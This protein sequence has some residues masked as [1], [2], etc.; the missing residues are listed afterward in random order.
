MTLNLKEIIY[1]KQLSTL[2][3]NLVLASYQKKLGDKLGVLPGTE[4]LEATRV[5]EAGNIPISLCDRDVR[6]TMRRAWY[7]TSFF[8]KVTFSPAFSAACWTIPRLRKKNS[9]N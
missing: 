8:K 7:A 3:I 2:M 4:L 6:T 5:A 9:P 1:K